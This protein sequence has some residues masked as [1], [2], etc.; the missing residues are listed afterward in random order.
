[1]KRI[2]VLTLGLLAA[3][4]IATAQETKETKIERILAVTDSPDQAFAQVRAMAAS[5]LPPGTTPEQRAMVEARMMELVK[6]RRDKVH[7]QM[8]KVYAEI[9]SDQEIDGM[10]AFY[11]SPAGRSMAQKAPA[12]LAGTTRAMQSLVGDTTAGEIQRIIREAA[13]K[14]APPQLALLAQDSIPSTRQAPDLLLYQ[15]GTGSVKL[16]SWRDRVTVVVFVSGNCERCMDAIH[17]LELLV[18]DLPMHVA[19]FLLDDTQA[20]TSYLLYFRSSYYSTMRTVNRKEALQ[21]LG[22]KAG[23]TIVTPLVSVIDKQ[24]VIR[25]QSE[26]PN[27]SDTRAYPVVRKWIA[28]VVKLP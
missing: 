28:D 11:E 5:R 1:M 27:L 17:V 21:W 6:A 19:I 12:L 23:E 24:G 7:P 13:P 2:R 14:A 25:S 4:S 15:T 10:L 26:W 20:D 16:S 22:L 8:V 9:Y 3:G 18:Q